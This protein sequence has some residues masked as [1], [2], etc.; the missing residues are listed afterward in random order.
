MCYR[1]FDIKINFPYLCEI[2]HEKKNVKWIFFFFL[3]LNNLKKFEPSAAPG[4]TTPTLRSHLLERA[5]EGALQ[6]GCYACKRC[7]RNLVSETIFSRE[8]LLCNLCCTSALVFSKLCMFERS[9]S[10]LVMC[11]RHWTTNLGHYRPLANHHTTK[12]SRLVSK[13]LTQLHIACVLWS[14]PPNGKPL[15]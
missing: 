14:Q 3:I 4:P 10:F 6:E 11:T 9:T 5:L 8:V 15:T 1:I 2:L 7:V 12:V 13:D